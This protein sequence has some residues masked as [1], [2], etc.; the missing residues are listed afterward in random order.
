MEQPPR[1]V[2]MLTDMEGMMPAAPPD[3]PVLWISS[4]STKRTAPFGEVVVLE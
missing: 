2:I 3:V 1:C 4:R